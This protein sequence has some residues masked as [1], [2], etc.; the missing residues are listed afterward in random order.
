MLSQ[1]QWWQANIIIK[2]CVILAGM[3]RG[4]TEAADKPESNVEKYINNQQKQLGE[5]LLIECQC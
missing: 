1:K 2:T 4:V 3:L 5:L